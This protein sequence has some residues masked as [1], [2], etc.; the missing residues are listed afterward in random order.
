MWAL[1]Q[2][3]A[4]PCGDFAIFGPHGYRMMKKLRLQGMQI[5]PGGDLRQNEVAGP[6]TFAL[7]SKCYN[8][9]RT[10]AIMLKAVGVCKLD[11]YHDHQKAYAERYGPRVWHLQYQGEGRMRSER[12]IYHKRQ[13]AEEHR[14]LCALGAASDYNPERP[15]DYVWGQSVE[16]HYFWRR[17]VEEPALLIVARTQSWDSLIDGDVEIASN[18]N[19]PQLR[20]RPRKDPDFLATC[21]LSEMKHSA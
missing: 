21:R 9:F 20:K 7:W 5:M 8:V 14:K 17:E 18:Q 1:I 2:A 15:W 19:E 11:R 12:R 6:P 10:T 13:G 4:P 3:G 16:D